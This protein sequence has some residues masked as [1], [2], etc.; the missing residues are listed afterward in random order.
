MN[1]K[2]ETKIKAERSKL[3]ALFKKLT[4][5]PELYKME[6]HEG[7]FPVK[8][9]LE[10][11]GAIFYTKE[12]LGGFPAKLY[13]KVV[14]INPP[15]IFTFKLIKPLK[16]LDI[17]G[18]F[19]TKAIDKETTLL[20]LQIYQ[21]KSSSIIKRLLAAPIFF[22]PIRNVVKAQITKEVEL[23]KNLMRQQL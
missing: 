14:S 18:D 4:S 12:Q 5:K 6:T 13:F 10:E 2:A 8:G 20:T 1:I 7:I 21:D 11:P 15:E 22:F 9:N 3:F 19:K 16:F 23:V 17:K